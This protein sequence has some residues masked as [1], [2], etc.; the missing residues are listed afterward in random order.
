MNLQERFDWVLKA[1]KGHIYSASFMA[2]L[3]KEPESLMESMLESAVSSGR[4]VSNEWDTVKVYLDSD[5]GGT[6][7]H[8]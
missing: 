3:L 2:Q 8:V 6:I 4:L 1:S 5:I 7:L